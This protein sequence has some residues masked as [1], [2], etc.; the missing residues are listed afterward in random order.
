[1]ETTTHNN[2]LSFAE[3]KMNIKHC[4]AP[5]FKTSK[6]GVCC[7]AFLLSVLLSILQ[8]II[9]TSF[10]RRRVHYPRGED[11]LSLITQ[12]LIL[13]QKGRKRRKKRKVGLKSPP[14]SSQ[15]TLDQLFLFSPEGPVGNALCCQNAERWCVW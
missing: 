10:K 9:S 3:Q 4:F 8:I 11:G 1:M 5:V 2:K 7:S 13:Y 6:R 12:R 14:R 15:R